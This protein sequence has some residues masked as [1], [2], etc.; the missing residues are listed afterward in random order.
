MDMETGMRGFMLAGKD[1]FLEPYHIGRQR[2][3]T[4]IAE[5]SETVSDNAAQVTLL[6]ETK[7]TINDWN[8][9]IVEPSIAFRKQVGSGKT[10]DE[11]ASLIGE[12]KGKQYFDQFR[13]QIATFKERE[14]ALMA[15]RAASLDSTSAFVINTSIFGTLLAMIVGIGLIIFLTKNIMRQL[16]G[17]PAFIAQI[18]KNVAAGDLQ[19]NA[20]AMAQQQTVGVFA[21]LQHMVKSLTEKAQA[22]QAIASGDLTMKIHLASDRDMLGISLQKMV[23]NLNH[24][25][26]QVQTIS[27]SIAK[28]SRQL[29]E[30]SKN[31]AEGS[32]EQS[33]NLENISSSL[34]QLTSQTGENA[35]N[36]RQARALSSDAQRAAKEGSDEMRRMM[37]A[38]QEINNSSQSIEAFIKTIDEI[39]AQTNLLA[40]NAAIEAAR[41]GEQGRGFAVVAD[42][43]RSLAARSATTAQ[44]TS[45]L[46]AQSTEKTQ[47]GINIAG[48]TMTAL[49]KIFAN[50]DEASDL[51]AQIASACSEQ[52]QAAEYIS[53]SVS[54][55]D[56]VAQSS[57]ETAK[58]AAA[59]SEELAKQVLTLNQTLKQFK[60]K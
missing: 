31:V 10:M 1:D 17:E 20:E 26:S 33:S 3:N 8:N 14:R 28:G 19:A 59:T 32:Q 2:F 21:E 39:A 53:E 41:A 12:A 46:I 38:M 34:F 29:S 51:V 4:L 36:A 47:N 16:G 48:Q 55:I 52:A 18:A 37:E 57:S 44:E 58:S 23:E 15:Q 54:E 5:L 22:A 35:E 7:A 43:V 13:S 49:E 50:V 45:Q 42:E 24:L 60:V 6:K 25:V 40:L 27:D 9:K 56:A 30:G 11:V